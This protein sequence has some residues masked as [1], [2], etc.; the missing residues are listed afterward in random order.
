MGETVPIPSRVQ[1][2]IAIVGAATTIA[3]I[4]P[5]WHLAAGGDVAW[6]PLVAAVGV[7]VFLATSRP[8]GLLQIG[9]ASVTGILLSSASPHSNVWAVLVWPL[10]GIA[11]S[12]IAHVSSRIRLERPLRA[13]HDAALTAGIIL[14]VGVAPWA[15]LRRDGASVLLT[16]VGVVLVTA[17]LATRARTER[18]LRRVEAGGVRDHSIRED[19]GGSPVPTWSAFQRSAEFRAV[20]FWQ[21]NLGPFRSAPEG[22]ARLTRPR[23]PNE[24]DWTRL[25]TVAVAVGLATL[26]L[27]GFAAS[28]PIACR[29]LS[30][31]TANARELRNAL[32][33]Y[34]GIFGSGTCPTVAQLVAGREI[35]SASKTDDPWGHDYRI[36]CTDDD[37]TVTSAG[38][39]G[40][41]GTKDDV[42][43]PRPVEPGR[44]CAEMQEF[45]WRS[46]SSAWRAQWRSS[47]PG[48]RSRRREA[49]SRSPAR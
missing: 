3:V 21:G 29:E 43:V 13:V 39:D 41:F 1:L 7:L 37:V 45:G 24:P 48:G 5:W 44:A 18:W 36:V 19:T 32:Q 33:R 6:V 42:V 2:A 23:H 10:Y 27:M 40:R 22:V 4:G 35:D 31:N 15:L 49:R 46:G 12:E 9:V 14:V 16:V 20:L 38:K 11:T 25:K 34:R 8:R 17:M 26:G 47:P 28:R 30:I